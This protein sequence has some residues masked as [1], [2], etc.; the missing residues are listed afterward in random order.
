MTSLTGWENNG[1]FRLVLL[2]DWTFALYFLLRADSSGVSL[3][4]GG[5]DAEQAEEAV[6]EDDQ[7]ETFLR[8]TGPRATQAGQAGT[9]QEKQKEFHTDQIG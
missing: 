8:L 9:K 4:D 2:S 6:V 1:G 7:M 5:D 3:D